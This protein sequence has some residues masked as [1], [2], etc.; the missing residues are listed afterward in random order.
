MKEKHK[1]FGI[2]LLSVLL[3]VAFIV[4]SGIKPIYANI[5]SPKQG[6]N[7]YHFYNDT[8]E[9]KDSAKEIQK[10]II[11]N[12]GKLSEP[13]HVFKGKD[14]VLLKWQ[15][16]KGNDIKFDT[17]IEIKGDEKKVINVYPVFK[18]QVV[19]T[20]YVD[21]KVYMTDTIT[22]AS[23]YKL[24]V[25]PTI[26]DAN[27]YFVNWSTSKDGSSDPYDEDSLKKDIA[28]GKTDIKLYAITEFKNKATFITGDG[29][30]F[31]DQILASKD[32]ILDKMPQ[33]PTREGYEFSYWS[34]T[35]DGKPV[36]LAN[37]KLSE[38]IDVYAVWKPVVVDYKFKVMV[39]NINDDGYTF[40]EI[41]SA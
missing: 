35:E 37:L 14:Q 3:A 13:H 2:I 12:E 11:T 6:I 30:S 34:L 26:Y 1:H 15:D 25:D 23:S 21:D 40:H 41:I 24:P 5:L 19:I 32:S 18:N 36:D 9:K 38:D 31:Q 8:I 4:F 29:A 22:D 7:E 27:K 16:E 39:Q 28:E 20:Y 10:Q 33:N 17:P